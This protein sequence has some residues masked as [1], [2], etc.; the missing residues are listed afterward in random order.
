MNQTDKHGLELD[1]REIQNLL[2]RLLSCNNTGSGMH[3]MASSFLSSIEG[4]WQEWYRLTPAERWRET[5]K[6]WA[7]YLEVGG[8]LDPE[9]DTQSPFH[10]A[11][12][13]RPFSAHGRS[14]VRVLRRG[15]I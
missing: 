5:E 2:P 8:S 6:L 4:E 1:L 11:F 7:F 10:A 15:G 12:S 3:K 14:G 9:P 13:Q